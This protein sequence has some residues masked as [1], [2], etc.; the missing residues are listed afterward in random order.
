M[1]DLFQQPQRFHRELAFPF[2]KQLV[3]NKFRHIWVICI[4]EQHCELGKGR[5]IGMIFGQ[6]QTDFD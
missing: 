4:L 1:A 6:L 2:K 5:Q 3:K